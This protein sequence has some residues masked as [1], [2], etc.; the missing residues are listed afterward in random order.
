MPSAGSPALCA[1]SCRAQLA[2][3]EAELATSQQQLEA[4]DASLAALSIIFADRLAGVSWV[5]QA[6][7]GMRV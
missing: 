6:G 4:A 2:T 5:Q 3:K 1:V 7:R